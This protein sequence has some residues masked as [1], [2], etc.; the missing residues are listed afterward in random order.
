VTFF[1]HPSW[2]RQGLARRLYVP[3]NRRTSLRLQLLSG[4]MRLGV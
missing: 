1:V 4:M 3:A 2:A